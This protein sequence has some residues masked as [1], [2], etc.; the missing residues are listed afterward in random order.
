MRTQVPSKQRRG[1]SPGGLKVIT[2]IGG[3]HSWRAPPAAL[4]LPSDDDGSQEL[5]ARGEWPGPVISNFANP[6]AGC[7]GADAAQESG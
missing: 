5:V 4:S 1:S 7:L 3:V 6:P 2:R